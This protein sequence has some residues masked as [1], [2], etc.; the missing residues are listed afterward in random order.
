MTLPSK[1]GL[2]R[3]VATTHGAIEQA[4]FALFAERGFENTTMDAIA[5]AVG[6]GK[7]TLFRYFQSKNDIP[8]G[9]FDHTLEGFRQLLTRIPTD[10]PLWSGVHQGVLAFNDF[11]GDADPPH[12][13]RMHLILS[14]P[15]LQA[16]SV[17]KYAAWRDVIADYTA[18]RLGLAPTDL[19]P[20]TIGQVSLALALS[21]YTAWLDDEEADLHQLLDEAMSG[22]RRYL[23]A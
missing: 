22:L 12:R 14:T 8:W 20:S 23:S 13:D 1:G 16:H 6:V 2:G 18:R 11:P 17:L 3:P 5:N 7:R 15:T 21:A 19:L 10:T 9:Q 4:A